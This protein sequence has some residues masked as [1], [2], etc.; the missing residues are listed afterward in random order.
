MSSYIRSHALAGRRLLPCRRW[1]GR[2]IM[3]N[4]VARYRIDSLAA[5]ARQLQF[6][7]QEV[8]AQQL[9]NAEELLATIE[10]AKAYPI[11]FVTFRITGYR[12]KAV[13]TEQA[14]GAA[15]QHDLGLLVERV[16]ETL[17]LHAQMFAEPVLAIDDV[18]ER[19]GVT[20]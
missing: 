18:T 3:G 20:S 2:G 6:T 9:L 17:E 5:L 4:C 12:P 16:S 19:F 13:S 1:P 8:R 11:D 14:A 15:L 7:P 10:P